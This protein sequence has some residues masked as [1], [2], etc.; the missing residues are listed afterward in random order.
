MEMSALRPH[1]PLCRRSFSRPF[2]LPSL[3]PSPSLQRRK[4]QSFQISYNGLRTSSVLEN[5]VQSRA[6]FSCCTKGTSTGLSKYNGVRYERDFPCKSP[7]CISSMKIANASTGTLEE[8]TEEEELESLRS[9]ETKVRM[10]DVASCNN[11]F[12]ASTVGK[13]LSGGDCRGW[14]IAKDKLTENKKEM[15]GSNKFDRENGCSNAS[16]GAASFGQNQAVFKNGDSNIILQD[17]RDH[18][19]SAVKYS[20][21]NKS[22]VFVDSERLVRQCNES[23][24]EISKEKITVIN[25]DHGLDGIAK[26]SI[27]VTSAKQAGGT[28]KIN[29]RNRLCSIYEDILVVDN[30]SLAEEVSKMLTTKYRH[31]IYAC[32]TEV[33]HNYSFDCHVIENYGFKV[34]GFHADTMHMAR[35]W[36]SSRLL[37]GGY[38]LEGLTGDRRVMSRTQ[39]NH[40]K[41]LIGKVSMKTIFSKK[42]LKKDGSEG[43][44]S[45][46]APVE[47]LQRNERIPWIC[48]SALDA[49][50]TLKLYESL[51][52]HLSDMPWKFDGVPVYG[53]TMYD[54]YNEYWRPFGELLVMME[55][56]GMLVDRAY[57]VSIEKVA[58]VEEEIAANRFRKWASRYCPDAQYMN[59]GSDS[60][61]RQLLFGGTLNRK[62]SNLA[63]PTE[64]IFKI[65][66]VDNV[67]EE[68]KK[69]PKKFRDIKVTS[70]GYNLKT[71]MYTATGWPSV[72]GDVLKAMAGKISADYD[73]FDEDCN[74]E[75]G[76]EDGNTSQNQVAPLKIDS[77]A[78]G[79]AYAAFPTE[80]EGREA[81]HAIAAL[82][83][84]C[85][86]NSLISNFILPL[87]GQNISGKDLRVHCSLNINT[88]T[89]RLSARRPNLQNQ[90]ALE[91]DR[92]KIRQAFI[93]SPGNSLIVADYGQLELR[94]L[95]HLADCKSMLE[96]F[97]AGGDFH[98]RTAMNMYP[99]IREAVEIKE[100][101]LEW[102]R[103]PGEDKP[104]VPLLKDA[105][106][107]ERRK[108]KMLNFSIAYGKTP[109]GLS[110][111][112]KVSVKDAKKTVDLWY[113]DRKEVLQWQEERK[114]EAH[115]LHCVHTLLGRARRFP[116][117]AQA[118]KYQK[119]HIER[120]AIN[121]PV[122]GSAADV[123]M[124]AMLQISKNKQLKELG[125]KLLLQVH[126]EVILEGPTESAEV[127]KS[128]VVECMSKP[129]NG[130]NIL[131][132]DLSVDAKCAQ[133]WYAGK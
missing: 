75:L 97:K 62:D 60:Q 71:E 7:V 113:N 31:L 25:G 40:Q 33:W 74:L 105:F 116:L 123:A 127:A 65:P 104:P 128:L 45:V 48:Y 92:Y 101:L 63:L 64:R 38:S 77:S 50:S 5:S 19:S 122:Q 20:V 18:V 98:S 27:N 14:T 36:D 88:E 11:G 115:E 12:S 89:G 120:A 114:K 28:D 32:D 76:D 119:G 109:V 22:K 132:V 80:E 81:C 30:I 39:L 133:N 3:L 23:T 52:G 29:L 41:D 24:L 21:L 4:N 1:C 91:K 93:A 66:N 106:A 51:K 107:S 61:L 111:D 83:Q 86:I 67:I 96:A 70:L 95:A 6:G 72:S 126:D 54:F 55:S 125:W 131:K 56:E 13:N 85:S 118:N 37:D 8:M 129:F 2:S 49:S 43:K 59:V 82:C 17:H 103:K 130:K 26:D 84:V 57:L 94:I 47:E 9:C 99:Y 10:M 16:N 124:C 42:K 69:A 117:M 73:F 100:V 78:Y 110:K 90:P 108:A 112:W 102:H 44:T 68:G 121:T 58:K 87:Q 35:L 53:K 34:S 15:N 79:T 46:I